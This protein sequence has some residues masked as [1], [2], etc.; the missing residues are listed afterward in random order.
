MARHQG[1]EKRR[2]DKGEKE[3]LEENELRHRATLELAQVLSQKGVKLELDPFVH[4]GRSS[5]ST[6]Q[7]I[8][9][10]DYVRNLLYWSPGICRTALFLYYI[11]ASD[12]GKAVI[13]A[14]EIGQDLI[15]E[16]SWVTLDEMKIRRYEKGSGK[17][18]SGSSS[19]HDFLDEAVS[20]LFRVA[21]FAGTAFVA[22]KAV[23]AGTVAVR[24]ASDATMGRAGRLVDAA[25]R[26]LENK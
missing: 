26:R 9:D 22:Y 14:D 24:S 6:A 3:E 12:Y 17:D 5:Y 15:D 1:N 18:T 19:I 21:L 23:K 10:S 16:L 13:K 25:T 20:G 2:K 7:H 8:C 11:E 4:S